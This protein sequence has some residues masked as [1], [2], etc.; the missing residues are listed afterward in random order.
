MPASLFARRAAVYLALGL[1]V[2]IVAFPLVWMT[3][4]AL[5]TN[6]EVIN[7]AAPP[8]PA[9]PR[10]S[11][12]GEAL[13]QAPFGRWYLN[14]AIFGVAA[15][16]GQLTTGLLAGYAFALLDFPGRRVLF[17]LALSGLMVPFS[18]IIVPMS[19]LLGG[20]GWL[21]TYQGLI[22]PNIAS[23]LG[24][25]LFRQF[26][27]GTPRE[28]GEAARLDGASELRVFLRVYAPLARPVTA[29]LAIILFLQNWN[30]FLFPLIV[31]NTTDMAVLSQGL[32][33][34]RSQFTTDYNLIM[35]ASLIAI[36][37]VLLLAVTA[38]RH[39]IEGITLG[40][41]D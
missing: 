10:W 33:V 23:G 37:P 14:T 38:Q 16:A 32:S 21:N 24:A 9:V 26:F 8:W 6:A 20:L 40:A 29:A 4:S 5:K 3:L 28:L 19:E 12:I 1:A 39:I 17:V 35:A 31:V 2:A 27:L 41:L 30:N 15:T 22:V 18:A 25:F 36:T 34:F 13:S 11:N 7:P